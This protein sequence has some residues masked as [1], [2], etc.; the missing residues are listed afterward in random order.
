MPPQPRLVLAPARRA[1]RQ[2]APEALRVVLHVQV[3]HLVLDHVVEDLVRRQQ[4]APVEAHRPA[5]GAAGPARA[6][7]AD[8]ERRVAPARARHRGVEPRRPPRH[9]PAVG[10]RPRAPSASSASGGS[11]TRSSAPRRETNGRV[12]RGSA[13]TFRS[14]PLTEVRNLA[15]VWT[16][17]GGNSLSDSLIR[18]SVRSIH[19]RF[20][21]TNGSTFRRGKRRG[22]T[23][24]TPSASTRIRACRARS[25][26]LIRY[27]IVATAPTIGTAPDGRTFVQLPQLGDGEADNYPAASSFPY[28]AAR[29]QELA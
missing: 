11:T 27:G 22:T 23:T 2:Q 25:E 19:G 18:R 12:R 3:G 10:T 1:G 7:A 9:A 28:G 6:L 26:R 24:W 4:Q 21:W 16:C 13:L 17:G 29:H 5:R 14:K 15:P 8:L 20:S